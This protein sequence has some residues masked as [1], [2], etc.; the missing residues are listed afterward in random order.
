MR[1][2]HSGLIR[3]PVLEIAHMCVCIRYGCGS[4]QNDA[5]SACEIL[6]TIQCLYAPVGSVSSRTRMAR[7]V[8][9]HICA[10]AGR[11]WLLVVIQ[12]DALASH[13]KSPNDLVHQSASSHAPCVFF[14]CISSPSRTR[15]RLARPHGGLRTR[16][17]RAASTINQPSM[18]HTGWNAPGAR[19]QTWGTSNK[20]V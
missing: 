8:L 14:G 17:H 20:H 2:G 15:T 6:T 3:L 9:G 10:A 7:P 4:S 16:E 5:T 11:S 19:A 18:C 12:P 13:T 1:T